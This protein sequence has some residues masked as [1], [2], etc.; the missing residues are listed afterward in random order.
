MT[1][2]SV[3]DH[4]SELERICDAARPPSVLE[5]KIPLAVL[6]AMT[7]LRSA[8][9]V[10]MSYRHIVLS[11]P[12]LARTLVSDWLNFTLATVSSDEPNC[13]LE[14]AVDLRRDR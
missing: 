7:I 10:R 11:F 5:K 4:E 9:P 1:V 14:R 12:I 13:R 2:G 6:T 8:F 3:G